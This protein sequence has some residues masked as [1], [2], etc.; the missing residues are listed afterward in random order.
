MMVYIVFVAG[1]AMLV[2]GADLL[3]RG[4]RRLALSAG[5]SPL[6]VGLTVVA[7]GTS[8]P[9]LAVSAQAA[10]NGHGDIAVANVLGSNIGNVLLILGLSA[11]ITP[12]VVS[13]TLIL[14]DIP[15]MIA[16]SVLAWVLAM[17]GVLGFWDG[18]LLFSGIVAYTIFT[19]VQSRRAS[20]AARASAHASATQGPP[21]AGKAAGLPRLAVDVL[22]VVAGLGLLVLGADRLVESAMTLARTFGVNEVFVGLTI[23]AAG[24]SLPELAT[25]VLASIKGERDIAVGNIIGSNV[26]NLLAVLGVS[27]MLA[28]D[29]LAVA[30]SMVWVDFPIMLAVAVA[31]LPVLFTGHLVARWEGLV[32][33]AYYAA[34][35]GFRYLSTTAHEALDTFEAAM[36]YFVIPL[37]VLTLG[38]SLKRSLKRPSSHPSSRA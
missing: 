5:L 28:P 1:L 35:I 37:T 16:A 4:A 11:A 22:L 7:F 20:R 9:E 3:V 33:L 13:R 29:G 31:C 2:A 23:V 24:T 38:I 21:M 34:Y 15:L 17:D 12:L 25:S 26:F 19:V 18:L 8:A 36:I 32:F 6:V 27:G 14:L 10:V 30:G